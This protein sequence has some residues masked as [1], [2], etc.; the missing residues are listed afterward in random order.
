[1]RHSLR[2]L[3]NVLCATSVHEHDGHDRLI[4]TTH[5]LAL[6]P[7]VALALIAA[8]EATAATLDAQNERASHRYYADVVQS[9]EEE[10]ESI[11]ARVQIGRAE[12]RRPTR[13]EHKALG[14]NSR[15]S[16]SASQWRKSMQ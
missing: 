11:V 10:K 13:L 14:R 1:M 2:H 15:R 4:S 12:T 3:S 6:Q 16:G 9:L 7:V 5:P 8:I